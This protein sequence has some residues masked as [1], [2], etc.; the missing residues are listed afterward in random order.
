MHELWAAVSRQTLACGNTPAPDPRVYRQPRL[1]CRL[2][3]GYRD[4]SAPG[5]E[6]GSGL[7]CTRCL[8]GAEELER[9][10]VVLRPCAGCWIER[11]NLPD[12]RRRITVPDEAG[13]L[14]VELRGV[15]G[16]RV[17]LWLWTRQ[18]T[19]EK[20]QS[21]DQ[22]GGAEIREA[23]GQR[24]RCL[25]RANRRGHTVDDGTAVETFLHL[26]D[27]DASLSVAG[28]DRLLNWCRPTMPRQEGSMHVDH[29]PGRRVEHV[30]PENVTIRHHDAQIGLEA[31]QAGGKH[32]NYWRD[33]LGEGDVRRG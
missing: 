18:T 27:R 8:A 33:R 19:R 11:T 15:G 3:L 28:E 6:D 9:A 13:D 1:S 26:H 31:P 2:D 25:I 4:G 7:T 17:V 5:S 24:S 12:Q 14:T 16:K 21:L 30:G 20:R 10:P 22:C 23:S 32:I 29:A